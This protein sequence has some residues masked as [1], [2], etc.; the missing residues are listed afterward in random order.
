MRL[1]RWIPVLSFTLAS[2]TPALAKAQEASLVRG[3]ADAAVLGDLTLRPLGPAAMSGRVSDIAVAALPGE[4]LGRVQ[5]VA[6]AGGGVWKTTNGGKTWEPVFER[7]PV[8]SIGD[9]TVSPSHPDIV[10]VGSGESNNLRSSSW[11]DGVYKS[12]DGGRSWTHVGLSTSQHVPRILIHPSNPDIVYVAA[13]GPL[14]MSGGERG[15]YRTTNGGATWTRVLEI[16]ETTGITDLVFDPTNPDLLYAAAMQRERKAWSFVAGGPASGI[17]KSIDAGLTWRRLERGLP[18]GDKGRIGIDVSAS[19]PRTVYAWV[20]AQ[21]GG[22]FRSDDGGESWTRQSSISS[23]PWF[24]GQVRADP[25]NPDRVYHIGQ[26]LSVSNDG[27]RQW[28]RIGGSTHV[29]YH[30]MW[31]D[32]TDPNHLSAGNDG[33]YYVSF[34]AGETWDFAANLPASTFYAI[35]VDMREPYWVYGGLQDNGSWGAPSRSRRRTGIANADWVN[36]GGGDGFFTVIDPVDP[37]TMYSES[38]NGAL[39]RVDL[40]TDERK[41]IRPTA[42]PGE[43]LRFNWS[44]PLVLSRFDPNTLYFG[45]NYIFRSPD[46]GDTWT[47]LG[48]D[49]TRQLDRDTLP[50]MG[51]RAAGGFGRHDGTAAF[52]NIATIAE[53]PRTRGT[54]WVGTD[55]GLVQV[56]RD[57]GRTWTRIDRFPG[58]PAYTYVSHV[59]A[60]AH[61]DGTAYV[62]LDGHRTNDFRPYLLETTDFGRTW[63]SIASNLPQHGSLQVIREHPRNADLLFAGSEFGLFISVDGGA[64]WARHEGLPTVAVHDLVIHPRDND[65]V[66]GTH[67]R[68]TWILD[69]LAPLERLAAAQ[70]GV[71]LF[72]VR[73]ATAYNMANGPSSPGDRE[74]FAPNPPFGALLTWF[75]RPGAAIDTATLAILD[76]AGEVV[77]ELPVTAQPGVHR[78]SWDLRRASP[79]GVPERAAGGDEDE[80]GGFGGGPAGPFV[81]A[82][83]HRVQLRS[84]GASPRVLSETS[85][86]VRRDPLVRLTA[87]QFAELDAF[88]RKAYDVQLGANTL[89]RDLE[90]A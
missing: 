51:M 38:Q 55:D 73:A 12:T 3:L 10:F 14:W 9:V 21:D 30:A 56:T 63:T 1:L 31:I 58:V 11:G 2:A 78:T 81:A 23:L 45:A 18:A 49:L 47:K 65:L 83:T 86:E 22:V 32:P 15:V 71:T 5:Y 46:R 74:F 17:Y 57:D 77:R 27:G 6:T 67:G 64:Y 61:A 20:H 29:D 35:G 42:D 60:S 85:V 7:Q 33:G 53:S 37:L 69:D 89:V 52:G 40:P 34:D 36:V 19:Q 41:S 90:Q 79:T 59:E 66:V 68:G 44:A 87:V 8:A 25:K 39:Q 24:T 88:R 16:N 76:A 48:G 28:R 13:M 72:P 43:Q 62:A 75:V 70:A 84:A 4:R 54:L 26:A 82:G 50:I 80:G